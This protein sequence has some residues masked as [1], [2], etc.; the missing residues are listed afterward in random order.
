MHI[1]IF[2]ER[3]LLVITGEPQRYIEH[4]RAIQAW[5]YGPFL[6]HGAA[7][8]A[9]GGATPSYVDVATAL[10]CCIAVASWQAGDW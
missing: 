2:T 6:L 5:L 7:G 8:D 9:R 1:S 10:A 4:G 3:A